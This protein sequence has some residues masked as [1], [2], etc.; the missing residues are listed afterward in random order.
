MNGAA[1]R[2]PARLTPARIRTTSFVAAT[3]L[4]ASGCG[5]SAGQS[6]DVAR[7]PTP[8]NLS[9][10]VS[11]SR[12]S[13]SP[14]SLGAG[15]VIFVVTNQA[16]H[17][18]SLAITAAGRS[19]PLASTAPINPQ[20]TTEVQVD[21]APGEYSISSM[22][23]GTSQAALSALPPIPPAALHIGPSRNTGGGALLSP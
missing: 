21:F 3:A 22:P 11:D 23:H 18:E 14:A 9:V 12:I 1:H 13:V 16:S 15:P 19:Q 5:G 8:V 10:F 7:A 17:S 2:F 4:A 6:A 20:G